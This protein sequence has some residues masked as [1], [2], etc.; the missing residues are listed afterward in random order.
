[1]D[2]FQIIREA[3]IISTV[4]EDYESSPTKKLPTLKEAGRAAGLRRVSANV[5]AYLDNLHDLQDVLMKSEDLEIGSVPAP[6]KTTA[7]EKTEFGFIAQCEED[8]LYDEEGI[9]RFSEFQ[10]YQSCVII[11]SPEVQGRLVVHWEYQDCG[12]PGG[13]R[14]VTNPGF[15]REILHGRNFFFAD[16][17]YRLLQTGEEPVTSKEM[18]DLALNTLQNALVANLATE[19]ISHGSLINYGYMP[20]RRMLREFRDRHEEFETELANFDYMIETSVVEIHSAS[21]HVPQN[22]L[23]PIL[24]NVPLDEIAEVLPEV[25]SE[26]EDIV[27]DQFRQRLSETKV[28]IQKVDK[29]FKDESRF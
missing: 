11:V 6:V 1:M 23:L 16:M 14:R 27:S 3:E 22:V 24:G 20:L 12:R 10:M 18:Y 5:E 17:A 29:L 19:G 13:C 8:D 7:L 21:G 2:P 25:A 9:S 26:Y 15:A 4:R 28:N